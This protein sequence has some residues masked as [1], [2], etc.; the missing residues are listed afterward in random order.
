MADTE[1]HELSRLVACVANFADNL[2]GASYAG[3]IQLPVTLDIVCFG[4]GITMESTTSP[5]GI[6]EGLNSGGE[7]QPSSG[8]VRLKYKLLS[9]PI[10]I[11]LDI[12]VQ[13]NIR[14]VLHGGGARENFCAP[15]Q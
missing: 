3:S 4:S 2:A 8:V 14:D 1:H 15:R 11:S 6:K 9:V 10:D 5:Q 12:N 13:Q 7:S